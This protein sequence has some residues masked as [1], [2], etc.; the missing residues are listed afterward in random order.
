MTPDAPAPP[1]IEARI[2]DEPWQEFP[3]RRLADLPGFAAGGPAAEQ[4]PYG[5]WRRRR[6]GA[7]G[8]FRVERVG[9]RWW[10]VDPLGYLFLHVAVVS[11]RP[12]GS[13]RSQA[14]F[15]ERFGTEERWQER[16]LALLRAH[17]FNGT[18]AWSTDRLNARSTAPLPYTP[19][20]NFMSAYGRRR[21]GTYQLPGHTGYPHHAIFVFDPA[22]ATFADEHARQ[23]A[24]TADD[25]YLVGHFS[26]NELPLGPRT[27]DNFL[28]LP[29]GDPG[30]AA[31]RAWLAGRKG[32]DA[33]RAGWTDDD[34]EA[35][36]GYVVDRY[37]AI[38]GAAIR[39]H[40]P[41]HLFLGCRFHG[42]DKT[43]ESLFRAAGRHL[44]VVSVNVYREW[45]PDRQR[46]AN[47]ARWS[48]R[49]VLVTEWYAKGEDSGLPNLSG[50]GWTVPT[51][52]D[53]GAFYQNFAL[54]L[55][56]S[57]VCVGWHWFRY[58]DNDPE[59][60]GTKPPY[61]DSNKG[62]VTIRYE[63]HREL[64]AA[65]AELNRN[66][67]PLTDYFDRAATSG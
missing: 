52:R 17:G 20:W 63:P 21:G 60:A 39:T 34:R 62:I 57:R 23:L 48:G 51:Q 43:S 8:A 7:T 12:G 10:L 31:A 56:E 24:A 16:T 42:A 30:Y 38:V 1:L 13:P 27:L 40:D 46:V 19:I 28:S 53:R 29:E 47:W 58:M 59:D 33:H 41:R 44:D 22:F 3:T 55:L 6:V 37:F 64:L 4:S 66:L 9:D 11:V 5:G 15:R 35:F 36:R 67:Y 18:G 65:M 54:G 32:P 26:D 25:P 14:A 61:Q 49:P 50:A 45:T 2:K